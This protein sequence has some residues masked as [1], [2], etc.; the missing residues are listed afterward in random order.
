MHNG[1]LVHLFFMHLYLMH[2][3]FLETFSPLTL[4][5]HELLVPYQFM[6]KQALDTFN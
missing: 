1:Y 3:T 6:V 5:P 4:T 2:R